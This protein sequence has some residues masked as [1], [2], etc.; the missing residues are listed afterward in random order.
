MDCELDVFSEV[1]VSNKHNFLRT[2]GVPGSPE[3]AFVRISLNKHRFASIL[4]LD[5][6][7]GASSSWEIVASQ[8]NQGRSGL[9]RVRSAL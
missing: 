5:R 7:D 4:G 8:V 2:H 3:R 6:V 9:G 1:F